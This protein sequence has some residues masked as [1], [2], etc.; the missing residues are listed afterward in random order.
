MAGQRPLEVITPPNM[1]RAKVG[2]RLGGLNLA[3][4]ERAEAALRQMAHEF[5]AWLKTEVEALDAAR[6]TARREGFANGAR[7]ELV[8]HAHDLKGMGGSYGYP[9]VSRLSGL[10]ST[11]LACESATDEA[12]MRLVDAHVDA[13]RA[14]VRD[15]IKNDDHPVSQALVEELERRVSEACAA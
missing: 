9:I 2:G 8:R 15:E 3:A 5:D 7:A 12:A 11:L 1:L 10:L 6:E 4:V 14:A 13:I